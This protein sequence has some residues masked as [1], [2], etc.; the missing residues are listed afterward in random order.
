[1]TFPLLP[2]PNLVLDLATPSLEW[3]KA[4]LTWVVVMPQDSLPAKCGHGRELKLWPKV[5]SLVSQQL[6]HQSTTTTTTTSSTTTTTTTTTTTSGSISSS[7][8]SSSSS[9]LNCMCDVTTTT[10]PS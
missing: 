3:C 8:S 6:H 9:G 10:P 2:Q 7:S 1:M 5:T 4:E